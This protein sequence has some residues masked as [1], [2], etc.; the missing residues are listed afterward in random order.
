VHAPPAPQ[1]VDVGWIDV[2]WDRAAH[3]RLR[4]AA[5]AR[6]TAEEPL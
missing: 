2:P 6:H 3:D 1:R 4:N 5:V